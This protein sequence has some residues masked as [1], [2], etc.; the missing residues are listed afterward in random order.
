MGRHVEI[1]AGDV[2]VG[3]LGIEAISYGPPAMSNYPLRHY[4]GR[5]GEGA[6]LECACLLARHADWSER[7]VAPETPKPSRA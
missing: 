7:A 4:L 6:T 2:A 3:D 1:D 5:K